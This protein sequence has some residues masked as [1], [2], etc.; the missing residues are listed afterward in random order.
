MK[1]IPTHSTIKDKNTKETI[2]DKTRKTLSIDILDDGI[3]HFGQHLYVV[4]VEQR[5]Y[6]RA[7]CPF[8]N[9]T[10]NVTIRGVEFP[11]PNCCGTSP[12]LQTKLVLCDFVV[13]EYILNQLHVYGEPIKKLYN[14][15]YMEDKDLPDVSYSGFCK[16]CRNQVY[17]KDFKPFAIELSEADYQND[18][19]RL[20]DPES[21]PPR[22][23]REKA[24]A[25]AVVK[26][27]HERQ[28]K[29]LE[30]FNAQ[31]STNH[32]YPFKY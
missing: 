13:T 27:L 24:W 4:E 15:S 3:L 5:K 16:D 8:C 12:L 6:I 32:E 7:G 9:D 29:M 21:T 20:T 23:F 2:M 14:D 11:C 19:D 1:N 28:K 22:V 30:E 26:K 25:K 10:K 31:N 17:F 18:A